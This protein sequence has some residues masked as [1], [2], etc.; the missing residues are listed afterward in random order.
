MSGVGIAEDLTMD[1]L[2]NR[3][4]YR[5]RLFRLPQRQLF[6]LLLVSLIIM[7]R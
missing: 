4:A 3:P 2:V 5:R 6:G 1:G 7:G